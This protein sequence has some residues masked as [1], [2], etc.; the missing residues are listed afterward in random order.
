[1]SP[2]IEGWIR[3][4]MRRV[5]AGEDTEGLPTSCP[6]SGCTDNERAALERYL[7][8]LREAKQPEL[9]TAVVDMWV[10]EMRK[11]E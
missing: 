1:M 11:K 6:F 5:N 4:F 2:I 7:Y 9:V 3:E 10:N 8:M